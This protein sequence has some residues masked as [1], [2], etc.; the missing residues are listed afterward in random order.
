MKYFKVLALFA[1]FFTGSS[2]RV[3]TPRAFM[4]ELYTGRGLCTR[5]DYARGGLF[6][7]GKKKGKRQ[8]TLTV[9]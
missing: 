5:G 9:F 7:A 6:M 1:G 8:P 2:A 4:G 3:E